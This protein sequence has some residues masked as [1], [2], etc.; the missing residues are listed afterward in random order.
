MSLDLSL[1][2]REFKFKVS[3]S[4]N[5]NIFEFEDFRLDASTRLLY[6]NG[7]QIALTPKAVET[8]IALVESAGEVIAKEELI[9]KIWADTIV[10]ESNLAQYLHVL[11]KTLGETNVGKPYIET[12]KRRGYRF[13]GTVRV[14]PNSNGNS[15]PIEKVGDLIAEADNEKPKSFNTAYRRVER[16]G[17]VLAVADWAEIEEK[18]VIV[19]RGEPARAADRRSGRWLVLA[20]SAVVI[21]FA[22]LWVNWF[23]SPAIAV[24]SAQEVNSGL[25]ITPLTN[26]EI[27]D[28]ATISPDG[29]YFA[30]VEYGNDSLIWLQEVGGTSRIK[31]VDLAGGRIAYIT[32]TPNSSDI[33]YLAVLD[34]ERIASLYRVGALGGVPQKV[35]TGISGPV[36]FSPDASEI[37]FVRLDPDTG[38]SQLIVSGTD[39]SRERTLLVR[40]GIE[41]FELSPAWSPDGNQIAVGVM[42]SERSINFCSLIGIDPSGSIIKPLSDE[43]WDTC[44][45]SA[46]LSDGSG[47][48]F[49][50]TRFNEAG[51]TRRDQI[52][53]LSIATG[54]AR[55]LTNTGNRHEPW[56]LGITNANEILALPVSRISQI[57]SLDM[58]ADAQSAKR[59]TSGQS[60]GRGGVEA[61]PDGGVFYLARTGDNVGIFRANIGD[62]KSNAAIVSDPTMEELRSSPD[63]RFLVYAAKAGGYAHLFRVDTDGSNRQQL[64]FGENNQKDSTVSPDGRWL[65][66]D[67]H[68]FDGNKTQYGLKKIPTDGGDPVTIL[69]GLCLTPHFSNDG[70]MVSCIEGEVINVITIENG[71]TLKRLRAVGVPVLNTG[72]RWTPDGKNL[73]Y[74]VIEKEVVNLWLQPID[75]GKAHPLTNFSHG[76]IY[77]F[78][79]APDGSRVYLAHGNPVRNAVL[80]KNIDQH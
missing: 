44:H 46:W 74:R 42:S 10:E 8:L 32:F 20:V 26:A 40:N 55:R 2:N 25:T 75:G 5:N 30:Y 3:N 27:V 38:Q 65:V 7:E 4:A 53:Y 54:H 66:Y 39:G 35:L 68:S 37:T 28:Q 73:V 49:I 43:K 41:R 61:L 62:N 14:S 79:F 21:L 33:F 1:R 76:D 31:T 36:S 69:S 57:W 70:R 15:A 59:I 50:G 9:Q 45:R 22:F 23:R 18:P 11:R 52:Y 12:L 47:L 6:R 51:T 34:G 48:I 13:N 63:G 16:R 67:S 72:A 58:G 29:K 19:D 64:T 24:D 80:I 78:T 17:N 60:D 77:N 71:E 56:S